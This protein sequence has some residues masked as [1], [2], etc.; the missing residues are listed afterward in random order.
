M[1]K[2]SDYRAGDQDAAPADDLESF[3][4]EIQDGEERDGSGDAAGESPSTPDS[5][6][7]DQEEVIFL[8]EDVYAAGQRLARLGDC[9]LMV[10]VDRLHAFFVGNLP[11]G[12]T[13]QEVMKVLQEAGISFGIKVNRIHNALP[14]KKKTRRRAKRKTA[15]P[16][17]EK[18]E[19]V[20]AEGQPPVA[21]G[22]AR[23]EYG[24]RVVDEKEV[25]QVKKIMGEYSRDRIERCRIP[26]PLVRS[27]QRLAQAIQESGRPGRDVFGEEIPPA[28]PPET[29]LK[30]GENVALTGDGQG[31]TAEIYGYAGLVDGQVEVLSPIWVSRDLLRVFFV[32]LPQTGDFP[33][34][35]V[36]EIHALLEREEIVH[37]IDEKELVRL[38]EKMG[39][40]EGVAPMTLIARGTEAVPGKD[41]EWEFLCDP[42]LTQYFGEIRRVCTRSPNVQY[43][44]DYGKGL[45]GKAA[46]AGERLALKQSPTPGEMGIDV[47]GE[48]FS[49]DEPRDAALEVGEQI[50]LAEDGMS[51]YAEIFG[52]IG[53]GKKR[54]RVQIVSPIWI[55]PDRMAAYF[56]NLS[57]LGEKRSPTPGEMDRLLER[58][59]VCYGVE[60]RTIEVFCEKMK[61]GIPTATAVRLARGREPQPGADGRFDFAVDVERKH[62][63]FRQDGSIDFKQLNLTPLLEEGQLIGV[64]IP[65]TEGSPGMDISGRKLPA[66]EVRPIS[67]DAGENVRPVREEGKPDRFYAR[68]GGELVVVERVEGTVPVVHLKVYETLVVKGDVDYGTGNIDYPGNVRIEGSVKA[69]FEVKAKGN[70][71]VGDSVEDGAR[72]TA[73]DHVAVEHGISGGQTRVI[74]GGS[75]FAKFV[76]GARVSARGDL[77]LSEYAFNASLRADGAV[78]V[79]GTTG[80][81][82]SGVI[83][84]GLVMAGRQVRACSI[85]TDASRP[86]QVVAGVDA[87]LLKQASDLQKGIERYRAAIDRTLRALQAEKMAPNQ[88][89]NFLINLLVR[90]RGPRKRFIAGSARNLLDLQK[91]LEK[92]ERMKK[93]VE[94]DL[95][96]RAWSASIEVAGTV[97]VNTVVKIGSRSTKIEEGA[98]CVTSVRFSL[99]RKKDGG[100]ELRMT[101]R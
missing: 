69:G 94:Q 7:I 41:A 4:G 15:V 93:A 39:K 16:D 101:A 31:C 45:A 8:M 100:P 2:S 84:G 68:I 19:I 43:L 34:P 99:G 37:A 26:L 24:F 83:A 87:S 38:C 90:A 48:E 96:E 23:I 46:S 11:E 28:L 85:G 76:N 25:G 60:H 70:V 80:T 89:R 13:Y 65:A 63:F 55:A 22:E 98:A 95:E 5:G 72:V 32:R 52:Y 73:G 56:V 51:C 57:Q 53:I 20:I 21:P 88:I 61:Q 35:T 3:L 10:S 6:E 54:D 12:T 71:V 40:K 74:A 29:T 59:G 62:G 75:V 14:R 44:V 92:A 49:P 18:G 82:S 97:A 17:P 50:R 1:S 58:H 33:G 64:R 79:S 77:R 66:Q 47:F 42:D 67:V 91:R 9:V 86:T 30:V 27:G 78:V 36:E 81:R